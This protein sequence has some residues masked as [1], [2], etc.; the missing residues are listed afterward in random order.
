MEEELYTQLLRNRFNKRTTIVPIY[1]RHV[2]HLLSMT[3]KCMN[4]ISFYCLWKLLMIERI[5]LWGMQSTTS[6]KVTLNVDKYSMK[7]DPVAISAST[8][9]SRTFQTCKKGL[10]YG[11]YK[12]NSISFCLNVQVYEIYP[13]WP[14]VLIH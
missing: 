14:G 1:V 11:D 7:Q 6:N 4:N 12:G 3:I 9:Y 10:R 5:V 2:S 13:F 8:D